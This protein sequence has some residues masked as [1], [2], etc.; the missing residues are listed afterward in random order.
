MKVAVVGATGAVGREMVAI[1]EERK[2]PVDELFLFASERSAGERISFQGRDLPV[3]RLE[4]PS[5]LKGIP[6]ALFSAGAETSRKISPELVAQGTSVIDNSSAFRMVPEIPL[7]VPEVN[8]HRIPSG[9]TPCLIANPN[10]ATIILLAV[11]KPLLG[12][13]PLERMVVTTFQSVSGTGRD[14]MDE[15]ARQLAQILNGDADS[16]RPEVYAPYQIAF[17]CLPRID[18]FLPDGSTKEEEKMVKESR[19]ILEIPDLRV[20]ATCVRVPVMVGH[21]ESVNLAFSRPVSPEAA[22]ECLSSAPGVRVIDDPA[23]DLYP[24]PRSVAG[25]DEVFVGRIRKDESVLHGLNL[26]LCGDNLRKGAA[27]NAIQIAEILLEKGG[28]R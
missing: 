2:F 18:Q 21:S 19:K 13:S 3:K 22:R 16:I 12:L 11:V 1:L 4:N 7:V 26:W 17:N 14:A 28:L 10:C 8:P 23:H 5:Q 6:L 20:S 15:L 24:V 27:T 25:R 9:R